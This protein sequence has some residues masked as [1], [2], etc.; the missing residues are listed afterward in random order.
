ME[1]GGWRRGDH[2]NVS[3]GVAATATTTPGDGDRTSEEDGAVRLGEEITRI[4]VEASEQSVFVVGGGDKVRVARFAGRSGI[5]PSVGSV[6]IVMPS[7]RCSVSVG[8]TAFGPNSG[9]LSTM[10]SAI[11]HLEL[12][13]QRTMIGWSINGSETNISSS[14]GERRYI[15]SVISAEVA[16]SKKLSSVLFDYIQCSKYLLSLLRNVLRRTCVDYDILDL[17]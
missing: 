15:H 11:G 12:I 3:G 10:I 7:G 4:L 14:F 2:L 16:K 6:G 17:K 8:I 9:R 5:A 1:G 13:S